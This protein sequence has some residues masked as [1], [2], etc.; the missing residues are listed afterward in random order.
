MTPGL[1]LLALL[2]PPVAAVVTGLAFRGREAPPI[3]TIALNT[4]CPGAGL[5]AGGRPTLETVLAVLMAQ[6]SLLIAG[7]MGSLGYHIP[8][9]V[10]GG[11]WA[12]IHTPYSPLATGQMSASPIL[13]TLRLSGLDAP[14]P[15]NAG[16]APRS[17]S[18]EPASNDEGP[19]GYAVEVRCTECGADVPVPVLHHMA[20]C[21]F[22][23]SDHLVVGRD[24]VLHVTVPERTP[25]ETELREALL[26]HYRYQYYLKLFRSSV[27]LIQAGATDV[28]PSGALV[29]RPEAEAAAAAA[30]IAIARKADAYRARLASTLTL[31]HT[32]RFLAPYQHGMGTL[33]QAAFGRRSPDLEKVLTFSI[34][35][36]E[37]S[38]PASRAL[39]LPEMGRLS[40]L[41]ALQPAAACPAELASLPLETGDETLDRAF[42]NLDRKQLDRSI[43]TIRLGS[44]FSRE[45]TAVVWRAWWIV[46]VAGS[47]INESLLVD[48]ASGS[49]VGPGPDLDS[50][51]LVELP[52]EARDPGRGLRFV[53]MECPTCGDEFAFD[54]DAVLH[55]CRNCHRVCRVR[56]RGKEIVDYGRTES[57]LQVETDLVPFW[58]FPLSIRTATGELITDLAHLKDGIDGTLDQIGDD[59]PVRQHALFVPAIRCINSRLMGEAFNRLFDITIL[60]RSRL[61]GERFPLDEK[62]APWSVHLDEPEARQLAPLYLA[63]IFNRRDLARVKVDQV[64]DWLFD[65]I[66][67]VPGRLVYLPIPKVVTNPFRE[68]VG[69]F[70]GRALDRA[71]HGD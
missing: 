44:R 6:A 29:D 16:A 36:V 23:G 24:E 15:A 11:L 17:T 28:T 63:N 45:V 71:V 42:G 7:S 58:F 5:A 70:R 35:T 2:G 39:A 46:D 67:E 54:S 60:P 57:G 18:A 33:Y 34:G 65:A 37:A 53:P 4:L 59:A 41:R 55:F 43:K 27:P 40:Y 8:F 64:A 69:R 51:T 62:P 47:G 21:D 31:V 52:A 20:H 68:Y 3:A 38:S 12:S 22:C 61:V 56:G 13:A 30:E 26:D 49:V 19:P 66:Q 32:R 48:S 14:L 50:E 9:M 25:T 10:V 1:V